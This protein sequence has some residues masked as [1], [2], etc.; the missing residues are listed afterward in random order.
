[1]AE[2]QCTHCKEKRKEQTVPIVSA[3]CE[4]TRQNIVI[5]R[6]IWVIVLLIILLFGS[7][8]AWIAYES[9]YEIV[10][11][12]YEYQV[13]QDTLVGHNNCVI[14]GGEIANGSSKN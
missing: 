8:I 9:Q 13:D 5:K 11:E 3:E 6:L 2:K 14:E 12:T 7:N 10:R 4:A 1:M